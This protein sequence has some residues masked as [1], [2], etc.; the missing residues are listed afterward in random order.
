MKIEKWIENNTDS[1]CGKTVAITGST[2]GLGG[3][4]CKNLASLGAN[5]IFVDRNEKRS[6]QH[7]EEIE[8]QYNVSVKSFIADMAKIEEVDAVAEA[9]NKENVD[10]LIINAGAYSLPREKS[11]MGYD[12]VFQINFISPYYLTKR[13]LSKLK[14]R[15]GKVVVVGSIAHGYSKICEEDVDFSKVKAPRKVYGNAK[16]YLMFGLERL[17][18]NEGVKYSVAHPGITPTNITSHYP[19]F[20]SK[21]IKH[22]MKWIFTSPSKAGLNIVKAVFEDLNE[23]FWIGPKIFNIWGKPQIKTLKSCENL[24]KDKIFEIAERIFAE[25]KISK[26][27]THE[28]GIREKYFNLIKNGIKIYEVRLNDDKRRLI[29]VGDDVIIKKEPEREEKIRAEVVDKL[30]FESFKSMAKVIDSMQLGL[31]GLDA[32]EIEKVYRRFYSAEKENQHGV[33]AFKLKLL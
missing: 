30:F 20:V 27:Q 1:L 2:G 21:I 32:E 10:I 14:E 16:R 6:R 31:E 17:L 25:V 7:A 24:E 11:S 15:N 9:L 33:V 22:P 3:H 5:L 19:K 18:K 12:Q 29:N 13:L 28:L 8:K 23:G 26:K 4:V